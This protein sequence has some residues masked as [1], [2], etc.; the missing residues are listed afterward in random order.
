MI[1]HQDCL[2]HLKTIQDNTISAVIT[3]PP[4]N[5]GDFMKGRA[6]NLGNMRENNFVDAGWDN[7]KRSEWETLMS[8]TLSELSRVLK[9]KGSLIVFMSAIKVETFI[10]LAQQAGFYYK[11]TGIWHKTN[12]MPRNMNLHYINSTES[13]I[14]FIN[15]SRTGTFNND[16]KA[17]HDFIE[18]G[19]TPASEKRHGKHPTQKPLQVMRHFVETLTNPG[20]T[21]LDPFAGSGSTLVAAQQLGRKPIGTETNPEYVK[22]CQRRLAEQQLNLGATNE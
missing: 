12:P 17:I 18:T 19:L 1:H 8:Q 9:P 5:L 13:W 10:A 3:D 7:G 6:H 20:D 11:T 22:I 2:E 4:Y 21:V 15:K 16:G 14:Y